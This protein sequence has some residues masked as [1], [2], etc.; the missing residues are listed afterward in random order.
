MVAVIFLIILGVVVGMIANHKGRDFVPWFFYGL[1]LFPIGLTHAILLQ[2][3]KEP[4]RTLQQ[5][6]KLLTDALSLKPA[7]RPAELE[8]ALNWEQRLVVKIADAFR[9]GDAPPDAGTGGTLARP[10]P[11]ATLGVKCAQCGLLQMARPTCKG[12]GAALQ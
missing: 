9:Q 2:P 3:L 1:V 11:R 10:R 12:C 5:Q 6:G 4:R 7:E 8:P